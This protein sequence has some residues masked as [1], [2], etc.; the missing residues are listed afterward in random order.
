MSTD[1]R[2]KTC[3]HCVA[4]VD[5]LMDRYFLLKVDATIVFC[6]N[7]AVGV[8]ELQNNVVEAVGP[9]GKASKIIF[10]VGPGPETEDAPPKQ[11]FVC[12]HCGKQHLQR[13][14]LKLIC[15]DDIHFNPILVWKYSIKLD[16]RGLVT[17]YINAR[18]GH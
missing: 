6:A 11:T 16:N 1:N 15:G 14:M 7:C 17:N 18:I 13:S 10:K 4:I 8:P 3:K 9:A 2:F 5:I 12:V